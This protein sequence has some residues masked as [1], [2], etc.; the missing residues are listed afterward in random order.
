MSNGIIL[1]GYAECQVNSIS[2]TTNS[3]F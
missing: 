2:S 3:I 1:T